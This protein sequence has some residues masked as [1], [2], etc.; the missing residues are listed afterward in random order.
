MQLSVLWEINDDDDN[1]NLI[2]CATATVI[3]RVPKK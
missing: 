1:D 2:S 3:H